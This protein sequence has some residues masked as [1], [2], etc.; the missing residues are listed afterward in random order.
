MRCFTKVAAA[1]LAVAALA[2]SPGVAQAD[3]GICHNGRLS[4]DAG[5]GCAD[6]LY[7][8]QHGARSSGICFN[9]ILSDDAGQGCADGLYERVYGSGGSSSGP[10]TSSAPVANSPAPVSNGYGG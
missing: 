7:A 6:G 4:D 8:P 5:Q 10:R 9:G 2:V 1:A 3:P